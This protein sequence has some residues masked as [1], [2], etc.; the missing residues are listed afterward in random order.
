MKG[1]VDNFGR[2]EVMRQ[3]YGKLIRLIAI[4]CFE[5]QPDIFVQIRALDIIGRFIEIQLNQIV[6]KR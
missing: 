6:A 2:F 4:Q 5:R 3:R 1:F